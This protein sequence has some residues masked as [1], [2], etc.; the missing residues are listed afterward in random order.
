M[1]DR[2]NGLGRRTN[3]G[4]PLWFK[5]WFGLVGLVALSIMAGTV[6][7]LVQVIH[8]GPEGIGRQIGAVFKGFQEGQR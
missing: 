4:T 2:L 3:M 1:R 7:F 8:A 5:I 6:W